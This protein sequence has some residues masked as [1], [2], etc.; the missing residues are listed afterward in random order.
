MEE[1]KELEEMNRKELIKAAKA[2]GEELGMSIPFGG[3]KTE[4]YFE[5]AKTG[6]GLIPN[7]VKRKGKK[8]VPLGGL[9]Q[10]L[11]VPDRLKDP[12]YVERIFNDMGSR[13]LD[14]ETAGY[15]FVYDGGTDEADEHKGAR[16]GIGSKV[17]FNVGPGPDGKPMKGY[18][19]RTRKEWYKEDQSE[20][21]KELDK[22]DDAIRGGDIGQAEGR[23]IPD[24][25]IKIQT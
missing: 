7:E 15:E 20:K 6:K 22:I 16:D 5:M 17:S 14:A 25:G 21:Q 13:L 10:K 12:N 24:S 3:R 1:E 2:K 4:E 23:Y 18:L 11:S 9:R 8:R 19:M